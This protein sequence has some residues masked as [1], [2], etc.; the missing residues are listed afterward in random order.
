MTE[1]QEPE[2]HTH[3]RALQV[4]LPPPTHQ[5]AHVYR[6]NIPFTSPTHVKALKTTHSL[7]QTCTALLA[8]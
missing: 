4:K 2:L 8:V 1:W 6:L 7:L 3:R 5:H